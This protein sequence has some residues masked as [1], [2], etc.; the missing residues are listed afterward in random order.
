MEK[1]M[2]RIIRIPFT[3][4]DIKFIDACAADNGEEREVFCRESSG[5]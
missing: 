2:Y 1:D 4:D 3:E 5:K